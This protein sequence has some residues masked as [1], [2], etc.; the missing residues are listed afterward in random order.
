[1]KTFKVSVGVE[2]LM[3]RLVQGCLVFWSFIITSV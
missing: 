1:M 2:M 3:Q